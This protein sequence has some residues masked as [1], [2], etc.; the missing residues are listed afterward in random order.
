MWLMNTP[1]MNLLTK[2]LD[3]VWL[4]QRAI[5]DNLAN[6]DTPGYKAKY[7]EFSD[8][9]AKETK[10]NSP[11]HNCQKRTEKK[12]DEITLAEVK[13]S[14]ETSLR[15][16]GN[17]VNTDKELMEMDRAS[18]QYQY[19]SAKMTGQMTALRTAIKGGR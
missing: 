10:C 19:L 9:L 14:K 2:S 3:A 13:V 16:D 7:V 11:L 5:S 1:Q 12:T 6:K 8:I 15:A 4:Q 17:N 18:L